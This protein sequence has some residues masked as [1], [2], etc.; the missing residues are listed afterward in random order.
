[1][2][3]KKNDKLTSKSVGLDMVSPGKG[4]VFSKGWLTG[5]FRF[6]IVVPDIASGR[7]LS[8]SDLYRQA[9]LGRPIIVSTVSASRPILRS[10]GEIN[11]L[12]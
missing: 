5:V 11:P 2:G 10:I 7:L 9:S 8:F 3:N 6:L 12:C 1:V 4:L